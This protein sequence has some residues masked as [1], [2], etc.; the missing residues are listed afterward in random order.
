MSHQVYQADSVQ[1]AY[2]F[3]EITLRIVTDEGD[4]MRFPIPA[5][6]GAELA[7]ELG[8]AARIAKKAAA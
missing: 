5:K 4:D 1:C 6:L 3:G 8:K 7:K 2:A